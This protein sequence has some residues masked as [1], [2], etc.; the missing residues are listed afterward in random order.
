MTAS[1]NRT[2]PDHPPETAQA[3][4]ERRL[5]RQEQALRTMLDVTPDLVSLLDED[6]PR[7]TPAP[8]E[9]PAGDAPP[10]SDSAT[11]RAS[12]KPRAPRRG[13]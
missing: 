3:R 9:P 12:V 6:E 1:A 10:A 13:V 8:P 5:I 11:A 4:L 2:G 7:A